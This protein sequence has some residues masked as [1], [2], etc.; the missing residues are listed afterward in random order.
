MDAT[1]EPWGK[2]PVCSLPAAWGDLP[3]SYSAHSQEGKET[4][5]NP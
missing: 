2:I 4:D 1:L 3:A 5:G